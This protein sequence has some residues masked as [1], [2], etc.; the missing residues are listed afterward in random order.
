M[1]ELATGKPAD[2]RTKIVEALMALAAAAK[3]ED[4]TI[5]DIAHK[6]GVS[7]ADFRDAFPSKGAVLGG[8]SRLID[9]KVLEGATD[10]LLGE[11]ARDRLFDVLMRRLDAMA[12]YREGLREIRAWMRRDPVSALALN[13]VAINS[14]RFMLEAANIES[15]GTLGAVKLQGL[16]LSWARVIDVW[17]A[18]DSERF[19]KTMA[20]LDQELERGGRLVARAEDFNR[21][22][23][24]FRA[25]AGALLAGGRDFRNRVRERW[26]ER[27]D[28]NSGARDDRDGAEPPLRR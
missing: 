22:A 7:L 20:F 21:L 13:Q 25:F 11:P 17:L 18:D 9:R 12:L 4:I 8:F 10:D 1:V 24:P 2:N 15:E 16:V 27:R 26:P 19:D 14:M 6:A 5:T 23:A 3:F 28:D